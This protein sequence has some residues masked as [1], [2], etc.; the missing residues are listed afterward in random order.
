LLFSFFKKKKQMSA[1]NKLLFPARPLW[2]AVSRI[3]HV[4]NKGQ[5]LVKQITMLHKIPA[6]FPS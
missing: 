3:V 1:T 5:H 2:L 6:D 4:S